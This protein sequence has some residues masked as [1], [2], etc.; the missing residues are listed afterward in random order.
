MMVPGTHRKL[1]E[2]LAA[3]IDILLFLKERGFLSLA[4]H[5]REGG[6]FA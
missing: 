5:A 4:S 1:T 6:Q 2:K 3:F